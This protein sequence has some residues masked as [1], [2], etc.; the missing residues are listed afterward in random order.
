VRLAFPDHYKEKGRHE[1][2]IG[3]AVNQNNVVIGAQFTSQMGCC[4]DP[5]AAAAQHHNLLAP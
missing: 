3:P 1:Y 5:T 2:V 4:D